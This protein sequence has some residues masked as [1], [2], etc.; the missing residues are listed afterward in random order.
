MKHPADILQG[1]PF[2]SVQHKIL[3]LDAQ[4]ASSDIASILV[5]VTGQLVVD[6]GQNV[7]QYSQMFHVSFISHFL[8]IARHPTLVHRLIEIPPSLCR[9]WDRRRPFTYMVYRLEPA[10]REMSVKLWMIWRRKNLVLVQNRGIMLPA[11]ARTE[12]I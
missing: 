10:L 12:L 4:P 8:F 2:A 9:V 11:K 7:L 3:T 6:D 5:L 1:L